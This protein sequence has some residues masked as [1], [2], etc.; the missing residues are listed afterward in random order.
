MRGG[1][2]SRTARRRQFGPWLISGSGT[3]LWPYVAGP[4]AAAAVVGAGTVV[5]RS[6]DRPKR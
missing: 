3:E 2:V 5:P 4:L 1:G 6:P